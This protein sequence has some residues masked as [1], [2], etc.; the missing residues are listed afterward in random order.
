MEHREVAVMNFKPKSNFIVCILSSVLKNLV[1]MGCLG[2]S[3]VE[4]LS[5]AQDVILEFQDRVPH[6][7]P[8]WSLV[9]FPLPMSL[10]L[11]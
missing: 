2:G 10:P 9:L 5:L 1:S 8:A 7:V 4:R 3:A 11:S 6:Q